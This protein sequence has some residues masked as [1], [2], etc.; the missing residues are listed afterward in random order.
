MG[1]VTKV[2]TDSNRERKEKKTAREKENKNLATKVWLILDLVKFFL[3][4]LQHNNNR[5][6]LRVLKNDRIILPGTQF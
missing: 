3:D 5:S 6:E 4:E 2:E 1:R